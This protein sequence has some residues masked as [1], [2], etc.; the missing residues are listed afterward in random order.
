MV[1][2]NLGL[3]YANVRRYDDATTLLRETIEAIEI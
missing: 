1:M 2:N 3:A